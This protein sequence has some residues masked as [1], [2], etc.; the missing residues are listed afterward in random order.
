[1]RRINAI[2]DLIRLK[3][4]LIGRKPWILIVC[5]L[6]PILLTLIAGST[7]TKNDYSILEAAYV[8]YADNYSSR[9]LISLLN[10]GLVHW[11]EMA[12]DK[13]ERELQ[14]GALDGVLIIPKGYGEAVEK[15]DLDDS[16]SF[17]FSAG[18]NPVTAGL[19]RENVMVTA[20][21]LASEAKHLKT[22]MDLKEASGYSL[23]EMRE[24]LRQN[25][26]IAREE[27]AYLPV[28][29][30]GQEA[31]PSGQIVEIPDFSI[32][33]LFLSI[34]A[35]VGSLLL[36][37]AKTRRRML[38][39]AGGARRDFLATV[40]TLAFSGVILLF[41]M[42]GITQL[43]LPSSS[44]P[45]GYYPIMLVLLLMM[46]AYGQLIAIISSEN[47]IM[48]ASLILFVSILSGGAFLKLPAIWLAKIGQYIPHGWI[49]ARLTGIDT[50]VPPLVVILASFL[51]LLLAYYLQTN[52]KLSD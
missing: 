1:M 40:L 42:T 14:L 20:V 44:R 26:A 28:N 31:A 10:E 35:L 50:F 29:Y 36:T 48:P 43:L 23:S 9:E 16:Y 8:D 21:T 5:L 22:L 46:L 45:D 51:V 39:V 7:V 41:L 34:F 3:L 37:D 47:R 15:E 12:Q 30:I 17:Q 49:M 13:A 4:R 24:K 25:T 2:F 19:V 27:G 52:V 11:E 18:E 33:V 38:S 32:E 6:V